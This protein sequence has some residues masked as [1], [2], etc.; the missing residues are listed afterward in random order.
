[1][2]HLLLSLLILICSASLSAADKLTEVNG[3]KFGWKFDKCVEA[4]G[5]VP[6][7]LTT[8][9]GDET[10]FSYAP[11]TWAQI[12]WTGAVLDFYKDKLFQIGFYT[13]T[14]NPD[15]STFDRARSILTAAYGEAAALKGKSNAYMWCAANG[16]LA[17]LQYVQEKNDKGDL[18]YSTYIFFIDNKEVVKKAR[19]AESELRSLLNN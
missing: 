16:N 5:D 4:V 6:R 2:K 17:I 7:K 15:T 19:A 9:D 8:R 14:T 13:S 12:N 11:A 3:I 1:M 18:C 10:K